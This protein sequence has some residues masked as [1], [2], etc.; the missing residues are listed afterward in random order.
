M[1]HRRRVYR[2]MLC[3]TE[4]SSPFRTTISAK[5]RASRKL[6]TLQQAPLGSYP[7]KEAWS[8]FKH[9]SKS[10]PDLRGRRLH[11]DKAVAKAQYLARVSYRAWKGR[12]LPQG[13]SWG[14]I[15]TALLLIYRALG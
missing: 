4:K 10:K 2:G 5:E 3:L 12:A 1:M 15:R 8:E 13:R 11:D 7:W 9:L 6:A 14:H